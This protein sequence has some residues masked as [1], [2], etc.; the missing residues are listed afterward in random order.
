MNFYAYCQ[1][2]D[3]RKFLPDEPPRLRGLTLM[4]LE[5]PKNP[6]VGNPT[7]QEEIYD[8]FCGKPVLYIHTRCG[9]NNYEDCVMAEWE[10]AHK[11]IIVAAI[12]DEF[13]CTYRDTY[14]K[15]DSINI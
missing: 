7:S 14:I 8:S 3:L 11:D 13:D 5:V 15:I 4:E 10:N 9:G 12:D 2:D 1:I 6:V